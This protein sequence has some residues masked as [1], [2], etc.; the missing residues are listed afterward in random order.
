MS[1]SPHEEDEAEADELKKL[2]A[3]STQSSSPPPI[4][5]L[6]SREFSAISPDG[7]Q[8]RVEIEDIEVPESIEHRDSMSLDTLHQILE[9]LDSH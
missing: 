7:P 3:S 6:L 9:S 5:T 8:G 1:I 2:E 4:Q